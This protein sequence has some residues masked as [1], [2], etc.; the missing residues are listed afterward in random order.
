MNSSRGPMLIITGLTV[1]AF[2]PYIGAGVRTEQAMVY[3][4]IVVVLP[5]SWARMRAERELAIVL[6]LWVT[7][8]AVA[9][10]GW[11]VPP[12]PAPD[13][14]PSSATANLDNFTEPLAVILLGIAVVTRFNRI[15]LLR[16]V[17]WVVV[18]AMTLNAIVTV[19]QSFTNLTPYLQPFWSNDEASVASR[20]VEQG[21]YTGILNQPALTGVLYGIAL[22]CAIYLLLA[23]KKVLTVLIIVMGIGAVLAVSKAFIL[24]SVPVVTWHLVRLGGR[25]AVVRVF[26][27]AITALGA[28][29]A[30]SIGS[31][32]GLSL[33]FIRSPLNS[34]SLI[35]KFTGDRYGSS[36][37]SIDVVKTVLQREPIAGYGLPGL[38]KAYDSAWIEVLITGG[39]L[40]V[41]LLALVLAALWAGYFRCR[42][43][44][45]EMERRLLGGILAILTIGSVG[46]PVLTGNRLVVVVWLLL[47]LLL[48]TRTEAGNS[49]P[50]EKGFLLGLTNQS[51]E[52]S[53]PLRG[54]SG[55][56]TDVR[57]LNSSRIGAATMAGLRPAESHSKSADRGAR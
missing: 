22:M 27:I 31:V 33:E 17:C 53:G 5:F 48:S 47:V 30:V 18:I 20:A 50:K 38:E 15:V 7:L 36:S 37:V 14:E 35:S 23:H 54:C 32:P 41:V 9:A 55:R 29:L 46:F 16:T 21:R 45:L 3:S 4:L 56:A 28:L 10:V 13:F 1:A 25:H 12:L 2:G 57:P 49:C 52:S 24:A 8:I 40:G 6:V 42:K 11:I 43:D 44:A 26:K 39:L 34:D 51:I 19:A